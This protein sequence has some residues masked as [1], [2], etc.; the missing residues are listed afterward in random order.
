MLRILLKELKFYH[1]FCN[2]YVLATWWNL[3]YFIKGSLNCNM[4]L[5]GFPTFYPTYLK[6][7]DWQAHFFK[8]IWYNRNN[9]LKYLRSQRLSCKDTLILK[10]EFVSKTQ[11]LLCRSGSWMRIWILGPHWKKWIRIQIMNITLRFP[12]LLNKRKTFKQVNF[13]FLFYAKTWW[14]FRVKNMFSLFRSG[15]RK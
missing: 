7:S 10:S 11:F 15:S 6:R 14:I 3:W 8:V 4:R 5:T 13:F 2:L 1:K 9:S 12:D